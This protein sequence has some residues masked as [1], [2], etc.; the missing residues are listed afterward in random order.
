MPVTTYDRKRNTSDFT[1]AFGPLNTTSFLFDDEDQSST[2]PGKSSTKTTPPDTKTYLQVQHTADGFPKLIR[3]DDNGE[4]VSGPSAA[5]DLALAK[6]EQ[7]VTERNTATRHRISLPPSALSSGGNIAPLNSILAS[8]NHSRS[9]TN[10][11][12]SME[13]KFTAETKRPA[14]FASPPHNMTN[15]ILKAQSSYSTNDIPT[16]KSIN[17]EATGGGVSIT[18]QST[19]SKNTSEATASEQSGVSR[20]TSDSSVLRNSQDFTGA[21]NGNF[22]AFSSSQSALQGTAPAF[23]GMHEHNQQPF[24]SPTMSPYAQPAFYGGYGMQMLNNGFNGMNISN[25]Y[26]A[27]GQWP[28]SQG[29]GYQQPGY[30]GYQQYSQSMQ[31]VS[32]AA[33]HS[34]NNR[35]MVQN[36]KTQAD[37]FYNQANV[38]DIVGQIYTLCKDQHGCRFL[39]KKLEEHNQQDIQLIFDEVKEHFTELMMDPFGNYL[40]QRLL[41]YANEEQRTALI[42]IATPDMTRIALNQ[43]G[44][45]ALQRMIEYISTPEQTQLI[46]DALDS[47]VVQLI[48]DLNGNHVIQKCLNHLSPADAQFIFDAVSGACVI[49]GTHRHGCCVLQRC[50]DHAVGLQKGALVTSIIAD[51]FALVQDPFGN[52]VVQYILDLSEPCFTEPL[53]HSFAGKVV[54]LSKQKFSSNVIEKC[55]RCASPETKRMLIQEILPTQELEK[56]LR[57]NY[58]NY[59]VQ[60]ALDSAD[61]E[62]KGMMFDNLRSIIPSIRHTPHGRRLQTK[63]IDWDETVNGG[64]PPS[65][66]APPTNDT[67][68][69]S[70]PNNHSMPSNHSMSSA[71]P[72]SS[73]VPHSNRSNRMGMIGAPPS[74]ANNSFSSAVPSSY[75]TPNDIVAPS[76]QRNQD[77]NFLNGS[78]G[79]QNHGFGGQTFR[80]PPSY[81]NNH[82]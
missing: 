82:F 68:T 40:C 55:I 81:N 73:H 62:L 45:R 75:G 15:G 42:S 70:M 51:A 74:W 8:A 11:R 16:L 1:S 76:P 13:V 28:A 14:L 60:T 6:T 36:R 22:D 71:A 39:Q 37:D 17:G 29:Q 18:S 26:A 59:V 46:I 53:C 58:A 65:I 33:R 23:A 44:T 12:R 38:S 21:Q 56:L 25:G 43:H 61:D 66:M 35:A 30:G 77:Y 69:H 78:Q 47:D 80:Q 72:Y 67:P 4:L 20:V 7:Q 2:R 57:D 41:E 49:V 54:Y 31:T 10:N 9:A 48:Q 63:L 52:Y 5:L 27:Q 24:T 19:Q 64:L 50:V 34:E 3:R 79:Y 32:G